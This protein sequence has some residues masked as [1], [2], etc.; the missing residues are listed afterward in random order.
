LLLRLIEPDVFQLPQLHKHFNVGCKHFWTLASIPKP[1]LTEQELNKIFSW[2]PYRETWTVDRRKTNIYYHDLID[3][4]KNNQ[5]FQT[6]YSQDGGV[7]NYLE[8]LCYPIQNNG[9]E[10]KAVMV[11]I[12]L[13]APIAIYGQTTIYVDLH[14]IGHNFLELEN[15]GVVDD[16]ELKPVEEEIKSILNKHGLSLID[17]EFASKELPKEVAENLENLNEGAKYLHGL[18][19]WTD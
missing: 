3:D 6:Y 15:V 19:Q 2:L 11:C 9:K 14:S 7:T 10:V 4:L 18:F 16:K 1:M 13:C 8:F 17:K 12:S 5:H